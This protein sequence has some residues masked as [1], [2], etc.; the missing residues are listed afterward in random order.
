MVTWAAQE[1]YGCLQFSVVRI[2]T[3]RELPGK[4]Y[5]GRGVG[6]SFFA[7]PAG[8]IFSARAHE[9]VVQE[10]QPLR[11]NRSRVASA[12]TGGSSWRVEGLHER[13]LHHALMEHINRA[14]PRRRSVFEILGI[15]VLQ[16][17]GVNGFGDN[18]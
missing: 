16:V 6:S 5:P 15:I 13:M 10:R 9:W 2:A 17:S 11:G 12:A 3:E 7:Q 14:T 18:R 1:S 8:E 4:A